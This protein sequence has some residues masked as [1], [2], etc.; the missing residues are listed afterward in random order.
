M[1]ESAVEFLRRDPGRPR[2]PWRTI[3]ICACLLILSG[4]VVWGAW[5]IHRGLVQNA[6]IQHQSAKDALYLYGEVERSKY[7]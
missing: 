4:S 5:Y 3:S 1:K 6:L 2:A 7:P